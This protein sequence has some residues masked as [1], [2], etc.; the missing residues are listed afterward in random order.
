MQRSLQTWVIS[1]H[2][3]MLDLMEALMTS[4]FEDIFLICNRQ[5]FQPSPTSP[6][7]RWFARIFLV[8]S[9]QTRTS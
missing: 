6:R 7:G 5:G 3:R 9:S 1:T 8:F 2:L 4:N